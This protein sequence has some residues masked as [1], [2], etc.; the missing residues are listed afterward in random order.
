MKLPP[1]EF[2][3][4]VI[5]DLDEIPIIN[6]EE[7]LKK[8]EFLTGKCY[9]KEVPYYPN[10]D[11]VSLMTSRGCPHK[12]VFC[13]SHRVHGRKMRSNSLERVKNEID[14]LVDQYGIKNIS[15]KDDH[16]LFDEK[17]AIEICDYASSKGVR[18]RFPNGF[19][20]SFVS[21]KFV[22]CLVRNHVDQVALALESGSERVLREIMYK[23]LTLK[24]ASET[25]RLFAGQDIFVLVYCV[26]GFPEETLQDLQESRDYLNSQPFDWVGFSG[27]TPVSGS[28][29]EMK[30]NEKGVFPKLEEQL[31]FYSDYSNPIVQE[32]LNGD[33]KM[34]L[35]LDVNYVHNGMM[36]KG[37]YREAEQYFQRILADN[38]SHAFAWFYRAKCLEQIGENG[39][40]LM[41]QFYEIIER[42]DVWKKYAQYF[43]LI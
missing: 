20:M 12:C 15:I 35:E 2:V 22:E 26:V 40:G 5:E 6:Y 32:Q 28:D 8:E 9:V 10:L 24:R 13:A 3:N 43:K 38:P 4:D 23:P 16:F 29:F 30:L 36:R 25:F 17:R 37:K 31:F 14:M 34:T 7:I 11:S 33:I 19:A 42:D 18:L 21:E 41:R 1:E 39:Q 27:A